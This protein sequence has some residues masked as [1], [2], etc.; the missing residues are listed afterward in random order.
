[1]C[2]FSLSLLLV[3]LHSR[4]CR[5]FVRQQES[6]FLRRTI[7]LF[8]S[9]PLRRAAFS[10]HA[11]RD[12]LFFSLPPPFGKTQSPT[13]GSSFFSYRLP[14]PARSGP[15]FLIV[16]TPVSRERPAERIFYSSS[17]LQTLSG[18]SPPL[19]TFD[20][21]LRAPANPLLP[22]NSRRFSFEGGPFYFLDSDGV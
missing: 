2:C 20:H 17:P 14:R 16:A 15:C 8:F 10:P 12:L 4:C 9:P 13:Q 11:P 6:A 7:L 18:R 22:N 19:T 21:S 1:L 5:A 3:H